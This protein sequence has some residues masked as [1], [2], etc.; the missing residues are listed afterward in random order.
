MKKLLLIAAAVVVSACTVGDSESEES[1]EI[2]Q[3]DTSCGFPTRC[4]PEECV[5][6]GLGVVCR[7]MPNRTA[8][9]QSAC[10]AID[11]QC[12][13]IDPEP[14]CR[15]ACDVWGPGTMAWA[16]CFAG[17]VNQSLFSCVLLTQEQ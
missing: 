2:S 17:C 11:A 7:P 12:P 14:R 5:I 6:V 9:C 1:F 3:P 10:D 4:Q 13:N 8:V 16:G 15:V